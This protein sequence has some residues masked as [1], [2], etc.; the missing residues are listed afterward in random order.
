MEAEAMTTAEALYA[1]VACLAIAV[2]IVW[3]LAE[4]ADR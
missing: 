2:M 3:S 4:E 1:I